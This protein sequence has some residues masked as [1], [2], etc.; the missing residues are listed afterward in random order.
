MKTYSIKTVAHNSSVMTG[1]AD[2]IIDKWDQLMETSV[3]KKFRILDS[4]LNVVSIN[5][6][7]A[8]QYENEKEI[9]KP[10]NNDDKV[11]P[12]DEEKKDDFDPFED[13]ELPE[14]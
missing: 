9:P 11:W 2:K 1:S 12:W 8:G 5:D 3:P 6:V 4:E 14:V 10:K 7:I 13:P